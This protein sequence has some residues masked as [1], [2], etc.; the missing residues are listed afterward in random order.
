MDALGRSRIHI[1]GIILAAL[2]VL[3]LSVYGTYAAF[4][5]K[6]PGAN[7]F[8]SRWVGGCALLSE[9]INPYSEDATLRI[10]MGMYGRPAY[11]NEDQVAFA[12]PLYSLA[13]FFPLCITDNYALVQAIWFWLLLVA[14]TTAVILWMQVIGWR[15]HLWL[16][17]SAVLWS[18]V[19]YHSFRALVLGQF[20]VWVLLAL[21]AALWA[22]HRGYDGCAGV[23]LALSTV[24][25]QMV[26]L[27]LPWILLWAAGQRRW[28]LWVGFGGGMLAL[29]M[30]SMIILPSWL[31]DFVRQAV[32]YPSYTVYGS[33]TWMLVQYWAGLGR[34]PEMAILALLALCIVI[35]G[36]RLWR[37]TWEQMLWMLGLLLLLTNCFTPRIATT[38]YVVLI[39]WVVLGFRQIWSSWRRGGALVVLLVEAIS[40]VGL[41][42]L[43]FATVQG[44]FEQAPVYFPFPAAVLLLLIWL[45][46]QYTKEGIIK[47]RLRHQS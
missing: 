6:H 9:G 31:S 1:L 22:M 4:T 42:V 7:D 45:R 11:P 27:A 25:P 41:W 39:P 33:L 8:Y 30:G 28:R 34:G 12:Y 18:V 21:V 5:S 19:M 37:G 29:T 35:L 16:W 26:Y 47:T 23:F 10:Q 32:A 17:L 2:S 38:N 40:V 43:F 46:R 14:L 24:K 20:A 36:W 13:F 44:D 15:P 3:T